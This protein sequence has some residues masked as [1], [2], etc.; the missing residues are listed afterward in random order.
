MKKPLI[1]LTPSHNTD[2]RE[3]FLRLAYT[4]A[5]S[6]A[7]AIP[8]ILPLEASRED[9]RQLAE[10]FDGFLF[11][12]GP[13]LHPFLYGEETHPQCGDVSPERDAMETAL[14]PRIMELKKPVLGICRGLQTINVVLGGTL[15]Q[16]IPSQAAQAVPI[17]HR[18]PF[19]YVSP[20][21]RV[22]VLPD[23]RLMEIC[24]APVIRVNSMHH[25]AVKD[26]APGLIVSG[27]DENGLIEAAELPDYPY[28]VAVQWHQEY[29]WQ[30]DPA[31]AALFRSFADACRC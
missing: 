27:K 14:L 8:V 2:S 26:L 16:D 9:C 11:T 18:Q 29:L 13:D 30:Q 17:A 31:A 21:H 20:A 24:Q 28:L 12:G 22:H 6:A 19:H 23:T 10:S 7:G 25:Q 5:V 3:Q 1:G 4:A 15:Y